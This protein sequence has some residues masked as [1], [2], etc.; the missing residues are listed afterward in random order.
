MAT[1]SDGI[2]EF[3]V[4]R[5]P[6]HVRIVMDHSSYVW[7]EDSLRLMI[8]K[9]EADYTKYQKAEAD[10]LTRCEVI[11]SSPSAAARHVHQRWCSQKYK[12]TEV[13]MFLAT[14][15]GRLYYAIFH[16]EEN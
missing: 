16:L 4:R 3:E 9:L 13:L 11:T 7:L 2:F 14:E 6:E 1:T 12:A 5:A 8:A 15:C 10:G